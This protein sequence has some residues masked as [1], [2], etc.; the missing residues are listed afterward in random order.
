[1]VTPNSG[2]IPAELL[3][4]HGFVKVDEY[5]R[6]AGRAEVFALGD[7]AASDEMRSTARNDGWKLVGSNIR[8]FFTYGP[9]D[10]GLTKYSEPTCRWGSILGP[11]EGQELFFS[12]G[13]AVWVPL[14]LWRRFWH[15]VQHFLWAGMRNE[16][17]WSTLKFPN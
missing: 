14:W 2:F 6:A 8:A 12:T 5:L 15:L 4:D 1:M 16:V 10:R 9:S 3:D 17:D 11:W 7:I 13:I